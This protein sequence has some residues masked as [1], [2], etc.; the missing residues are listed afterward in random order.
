MLLDSLDKRHLEKV[1]LMVVN[2]DMHINSRR[3]YCDLVFAHT[4]SLKKVM[5]VE[6][7]FIILNRNSTLLSGPW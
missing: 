4:T 3:S 2:L 5:A 1:G 7:I 6:Y